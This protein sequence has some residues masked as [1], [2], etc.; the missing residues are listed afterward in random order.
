MHTALLTVY[1]AFV[2]GGITLLG[3]VTATVA[4]RIVQRVSEEDAASQTATAV[5]ID[6]LREE[7]RRLAESVNAERRDVIGDRAEGNR[8]P[9]ESWCGAPALSARW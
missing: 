8:W 4:S 1:L 7:L 9:S 3:A 2:I 5:E 6:A